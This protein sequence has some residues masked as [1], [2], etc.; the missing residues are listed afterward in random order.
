MARHGWGLSVVALGGRAMLLV[1]C[2]NLGEESG[3]GGW[4]KT[5]ARMGVDQLVLVI[6]SRDP[7]ASATRGNGTHCWSGATG[8][9]GSTICAKRDR[10]SG[11]GGCPRLGTLDKNHT[12]PRWNTKMHCSS[13]PPFPPTSQV[14]TNRLASYG[15]T[16]EILGAGSMT[17]YSAANIWRWRKRG[18]ASAGRLGR[19]QHRL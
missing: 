15:A 14:A 2:V 13:P 6:F 12:R 11:L 3:R 1:E 4:Q 10:G 9:R 18:L 7:R 8:Q 17:P 5:I 19:P 16:Q